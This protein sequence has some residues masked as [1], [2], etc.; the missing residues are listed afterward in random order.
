LIFLFRYFY[1]FFKQKLL[2]EYGILTAADVEVLCTN[3]QLDD[4]ILI[5]ESLGGEPSAKDN[6]LLKVDGFDVVLGSLARMK[7]LNDQAS[8]VSVITIL[9]NFSFFVLK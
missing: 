9:S 2:G 6:N 8:T 1:S 3:C 5:T 4:L 7:E